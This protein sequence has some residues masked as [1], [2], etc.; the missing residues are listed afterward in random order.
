MRDGGL[1]ILLVGELAYNP[2]RIMALEEAGHK[3]YGLWAIPRFCYSTVGPLPFG[4]V[5]D[6]P[7]KGWRE[8]VAEIKPDVIYVVLGTSSIELAR[9]VL[10]SGTGIPLVW[11]FKEG[12][13]EAMKA[14]LW[15]KLVDLYTFADGCRYLNDDVRKWFGVFVPERVERPEMMLDGDMPMAECLYGQ[16]SA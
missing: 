5:E 4:H 7:Y 3:L 8:R 2:E 14:G 16:F 13:H 9:E 15:D 1:K 10:M 12:P 11:H 6:V